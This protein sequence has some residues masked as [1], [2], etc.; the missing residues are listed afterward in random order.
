MRLVDCTPGRHGGAIRGILN[1]A[2]VH[3]TAL[4]DDRPRPPS[5]VEHSV[6]ILPTPAPPHDD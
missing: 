3:S 2:I 4:P 6:H 5:S 1:E